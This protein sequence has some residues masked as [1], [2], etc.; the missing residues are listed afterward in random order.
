M[1][2]ISKKTED[3]IKSK[4][5]FVEGRDEVLFFSAL[6]KKIQFNDEIQVIAFSGKANMKNFI[7]MTSKTEGFIER[8]VSIAIVRDADKDYKSVATEVSDTLK[9]IFSIENTKN[10]EMKENET[11]K[12]GFFIMPGNEKPGELEDLV[13]SSFQGNKVSEK[14]DNYLEELKSITR[15]DDE[16]SPFIYPKKTSK[17]KIQIYFSS[18][19]ESDTRMGISAER[20]YV[21]FDHDSFTD[22]I[23]FIKT[24]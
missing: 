10:G 3:I 4:L 13:L 20:K 7:S 18:M 8:V 2:S 17:A 5:L 14:I 22:I 19:E 6:L 24:M 1:E 11:I 21:N 23:K 15:P 16:N 12:A 9:C